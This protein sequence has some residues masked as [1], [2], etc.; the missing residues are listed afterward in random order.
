MRLAALCCVATVLL[1]SCTQS[2]SPAQRDRDAL[3]ALYK[4]TDGPNWRN[5]TNWLS[6]AP[7]SEW[8]G[9]TTDDNGCITRLSLGGN[10]LNG[11]V[12]PEL[13]NLVNLTSLELYG[14]QLS[15]EIP[16]ELGNLVNLTSLGLYGNRL[17]GEIPPKLGSLPNLG[18]LNL[19]NNRLSGE[20]PPELRNL[21]NLEWLYLGNNRLSGCKPEGLR[22]VL[23]NELS[24]LGLPFCTP[25][26]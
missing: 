5:N 2:T 25:A 24:D 15:G 19:S 1:V 3:V 8:H 14:N 11:K 12:P 17:S 22:D 13:G 9:V 10:Q 21:S 7:T 23:Y 6:D 20:I 26:P 18:Y 4:A 16:P